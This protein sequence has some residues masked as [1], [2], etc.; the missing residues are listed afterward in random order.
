MDGPPV[1]IH[2]PVGGRVGGLPVFTHH[3]KGLRAVADAP[4]VAVDA[5]GQFWGR[6]LPSLLVPRRVF[7]LSCL[8][9]RYRKA[10]SH[11]AHWNVIF[12]TCPNAS[13]PCQAVTLRQPMVSPG[14]NVLTKR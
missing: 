6:F 12:F 13:F 9:P 1:S 7:P 14:V 2:S 5:A 4:W 11:T 10:F 3:D 8:T